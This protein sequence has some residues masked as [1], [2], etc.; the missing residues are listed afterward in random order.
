MRLTKDWQTESDLQ[1]LWP[2]QFTG[3]RHKDKCFWGMVEQNKHHEIYDKVICQCG[4]DIWL[5]L[6]QFPTI[7]QQRAREFG[8]M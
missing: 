8:W 5:Q 6:R 3:T 7:N 4:L 2:I 1:R